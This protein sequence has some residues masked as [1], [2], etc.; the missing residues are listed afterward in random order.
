MASAARSPRTTTPDGTATAQRRADAAGRIAGARRAEQR[1]QWA[2][3]G[4]AVVAALAVVAGITF[5]VTRGTDAPSPAAAP[6]VGGDLHSVTMIGD[7]LFVGGHAAVAVSHDGGRRWQQVTSLQGADAMGWAVTSDAVLAGGH[8]GLYRSAD[9]GA[10]FTKVTGAGAVADVHALGGAG[11]T[12]YLGSPQAGLLVSTDGGR[13][14]QVRNAQIGRSFMG[15]I[16]VDPRN[17]ARLIAPDM[18]AG[19]ASSSDG[20]RTW[21]S[22][23]G[24][25]A[26]MA[27]AWNPTD[28]QQIFAVGMNGGARSSDGGASWQQVELPQ[29]TSAVS[30]DASGATLYAG[31]LD[32]QRAR[33][34]RSA[35]GGATWTAT[36]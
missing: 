29:G 31:A 8:P 20:G 15:T 3:W 22:L 13:N 1:R 32:G 18:S 14:W 16:L 36:A 12:V 28:T 30:Y 35:D 10:T 33:T 27:A 6:V 23:G 2:G 9:N 5:W 24:P 25:A 26:A 4:G 19:L 17:P 21:K 7:A 34:Y 11:T